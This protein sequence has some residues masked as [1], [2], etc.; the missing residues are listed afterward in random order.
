MWVYV[1]SSQGTDLLCTCIRLKL[2][3]TIKSYIII[4]FIKERFHNAVEI[5]ILGIFEGYSSLQ[6]WPP[7][8]T[9]SGAKLFRAN[10]V[11][12]IKDVLCT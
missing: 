1:V 12:S 2:L 10:D 9:F 11:I 3:S 8:K 6:I 5:D 4:A 7:P